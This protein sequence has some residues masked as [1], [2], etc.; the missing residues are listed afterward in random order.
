MRKTC[1]T[2][3][4]S[5]SIEAAILDGLA[6]I[7]E[8]QTEMSEWASNLEEKLSHT[9]KY[10]MVSDAADMLD[11]IEFSPDIPEIIPETRM[12]SYSEDVAYK[13]KSLSRASRLANAIGMIQAG[14]DGI[15]GL[16]DK[17]D[18]ERSDLQ[19]KADDIRAEME[20]QIEDAVEARGGLAEGEAEQMRNEADH[21]ATMIENEIEQLDDQ[22][23]TLDDFK[24]ELENT[25]SEVENVEFPGM[26]G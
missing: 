23:Q 18:G 25:I 2:F 22:Y 12:V 26:Y 6:Q 10:Q 7:E 14:V 17:I 9:D 20:D 4:R 19:T 21:E 3:E 1:K 13:G 5:C 16:M 11:S 8:L 24:D 15:E